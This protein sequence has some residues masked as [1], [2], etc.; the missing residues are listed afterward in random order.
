MIDLPLFQPR[1]C[2]C[3]STRYPGYYGRYRY[4][5]VRFRG[6]TPSSRELEAELSGALSAPAQSALVYITSVNLLT[7]KLAFEVKVVYSLRA[8]LYK[9]VLYIVKLLMLLHKLSTAAA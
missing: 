5:N 6:S 4:C 7:F 3:S 1:S 2:S 9:A 8:A